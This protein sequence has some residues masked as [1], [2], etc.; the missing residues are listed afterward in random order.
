MGIQK[1]GSCN[2]MECI[3]WKG[4]EV[5]VAETYDVVVAG[6]G[7]AGAMAAI[8]AARSG[9]KC[10][11]VE[12]FGALGGSQT[13]ALVTPSMSANV[14][15]RTCAC[16]LSQEMTAALLARG[17]AAKENPDWFD[18]QAM[19]I[20]LDEMLCAAGTQILFNSSLVDVLMD[21]PSIRAVIVFNR[22][23]L[24]AYMAKSFIDCTGD[25]SLAV[26]AGL[27][28]DSGGPDGFNQSISLRFELS[29]VDVISFRAHLKSLGFTDYPLLYAD[30]NHGL[31][32][33]FD[34]MILKGRSDGLLTDSDLSHFQMFSIPG[35]PGSLSF[36]SPELGNGKNVIDP[37]FMSERQIE[38]KRA[39]VRIA[40]FMRERMPGFENSSISEIAPLLGIRESRRIRA[41]RNL[42]K[43]DIYN[44]M[45][46]DD[47]IVA[48]NYP[49]DIH[50]SSQF[51]KTDIYAKIAP[52]EAYWEIPYRSL[53]PINLDNL[54]VAGRC[55]GFDFYAQSSARVQ[56]SC[57]AMGE[58]AGIAAALAVE[59]GLA[60]RYV[61]GKDVRAIMRERGGDI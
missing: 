25:A 15:G 58:A 50:G 54:L 42:T 2:E 6:G 53:V 13:M 11:V 29:G 43:S 24:S 52:E 4:E 7:T 20:V 59:K 31:N 34:A 45:K 12:Q 5:R 32:D 61:D 46:F 17:G 10:L 26:A 21:G 49:L 22:G 35:R 37:V 1:A 18:P 47:G 8:S 57:R 41:E 48:S 16:S 44:Y 56:H 51:E 23:G 28:I 3:L 38:G 9:L 36:N 55:A 40:R 19:K 60:F 33:A 30:Y 27:E 14:M 39:I